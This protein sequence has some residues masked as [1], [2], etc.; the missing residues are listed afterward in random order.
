[1]ENPNKIVSTSDRIAAI[2]NQLLNRTLVTFLILGT[3][4]I[5]FSIV[6]SLY[7][8]FQIAQKVHIPLLLLLFLLTLFRNKISYRWRLISLILIT[9]I[10]GCVGFLSYGLLSFAIVFLMCSALFTT[11]FSTRF[12]SCVVLGIDAFIIIVFMLLYTNGLLALSFDMNIYQSNYITWIGNL[13]SFVLFTGL[14]VVIASGL[15]LDLK[16][17]ADEWMQCAI[18][19]LDLTK[20]LEQKVRSRTAELEQ[21]NKD[22]DKIL[23]VIAHDINNKLSGMMGYLE[24]LNQTYHPISDIDR[25]GFV[26]R[27][28]ETNLHARE[29][30]KELLDYARSKSDESALRTEPVDLYLFCLS[31]IESH[32]PQ[33]A[34]KGIDM[35]MGDISE[36][37][38]CNINKAKFSRVIDNLITNAI[39][40]TSKNGKITVEIGV[41]KGNA[42]IQIV[43]TGIGIPDALKS[44]IFKP[45]PSSGR[46]GTS[47]E[48]STGIGLSIAKNIVALHSGEIWFESEEGKGTTFFLRLPLT[49]NVTA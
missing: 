37:V 44:D 13:S 20:N 12:F 36:H 43:D 11:V 1:M 18:E 31:T 21:L 8:G 41:D 46:V 10:G 45:L 42:L 35:R 22:K 34:D 19:R 26:L 15:I 29:I 28:I 23:G 6:R 25:R 14:V 30:V 3:A 24:I 32:F 16:S 40:F 38:F 39:K 27:A 33:A 47:E 2:K 4:A 5:P 17:L 9:L 49:S 7:S 48:K